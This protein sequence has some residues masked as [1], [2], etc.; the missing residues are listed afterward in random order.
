LLWPWHQHFVRECEAISPTQ[1]Q[2]IVHAVT[3]SEGTVPY[4]VLG[5]APRL[6][7]VQA[8]CHVV[9]WLSLRP[10][11]GAPWLLY[12]NSYIPE[13][14]L[15][16][17]PSDPGAGANVSPACRTW[18]DGAEQVVSAS[19][20]GEPHETQQISNLRRRH[21]LLPHHWSPD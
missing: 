5:H 1:R 21:H 6:M 16:P 2:I 4:L 19:N 8:A 20:P 7:G 11:L 15:P 9:P 10:Q 3:G 14:A 13:P 17:V 18:G 12:R